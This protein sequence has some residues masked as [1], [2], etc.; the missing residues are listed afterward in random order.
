MPHPV[1][2]WRDTA[3]VNE[4]DGAIGEPRCARSSLKVQD[5]SRLDTAL[6]LT[7]DRVSALQLTD[8][9][10]VEL[11]SNPEVDRQ[12]AQAALPVEIHLLI[13]EDRYAPGQA[14]L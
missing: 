4:A 6:A 10:S 9:V 1:F 3:S 11:V 8:E 13:G 2:A 14:H 12:R 5:D 7:G